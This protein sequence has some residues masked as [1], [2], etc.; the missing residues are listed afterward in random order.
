[1]GMGQQNTEVWRTW[2]IN[3]RYD[4]SFFSLQQLFYQT[5]IHKFK[6][7]LFKLKT[8]QRINKVTLQ[9]TSSFFGLFLEQLQ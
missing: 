8:S 1:M 2:Y 3:N 4:G 6:T 5:R 7:Y 9:P